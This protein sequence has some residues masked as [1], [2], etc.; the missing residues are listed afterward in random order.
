MNATY[1]AV[2]ESLNKINNNLAAQ[3][4]ALLASPY[5]Q[6]DADALYERL[7]GLVT[8]GTEVVATYMSKAND[9]SS[10]KTFEGKV[11]GCA[12]ISIDEP[13]FHITDSRGF[14]ILLPGS[15]LDVK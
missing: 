15:V 12:P 7:I 5:K 9:Y 14:S 1:R 8:T 6:A 2:K 4:E 13:S 3:G 10:L 11:T